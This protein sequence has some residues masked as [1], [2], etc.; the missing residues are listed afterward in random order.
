MFCKKCGTEIRIGKNICSNCGLV[1]VTQ[2][3]NSTMLSEAADPVTLAADITQDLTEV[4][5]SIW[6]IGMRITAW[7]CSSIGV[8]AGTVAAIKMSNGNPGIIF[9]GFFGSAA[10]AFASVAGL[11]VFLD[12]ARDISEIKTILKR[13]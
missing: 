4:V 2:N 8:I 1:V 10:V 3:Q 9:L 5:E 13:K 6:I 7:L 12:M 11:M